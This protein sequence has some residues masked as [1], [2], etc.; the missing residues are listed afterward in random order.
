MDDALG[1]GMSEEE[2]EAMKESL[3]RTM[4]GTDENGNMHFSAGKGN[5]GGEAD[6]R[7][8]H[9]HASKE[10]VVEEERVTHDE[11]TTQIVLGTAPFVQCAACE[12]LV[13]RAIKS[14][15]ELRKKTQKR[16]G[17]IP[18]ENEIDDNLEFI[19]HA[20][21]PA[22]KWLLE[23]ILDEGTSKHMGVRKT[24]NVPE[25][26]ELDCLTIGLACGRALDEVSVAL[27]EAL[28]AG[29]FDE[30]ALARE[31]CHENVDIT[32]ALKGN[33]NAQIVLNA[34]AKDNGSGLEDG[35][36]ASEKK[37]KKKKKKKKAKRRSEKKDL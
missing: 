30:A 20:E 29:K 4:G 37:S 28:W 14:A 10:K 12:L 18:R 32:S 3:I 9:S 6:N 22:G 25:Q 2:I 21:K 33:C 16:L 35:D 23:Y 11:R 7:Y 24:S 27:V 1:M 13:R 17:R 26:C 34:A 36:V 5:G 19:C 31:I 8:S 15:K